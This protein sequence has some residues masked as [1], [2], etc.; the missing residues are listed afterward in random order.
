MFIDPELDHDELFEEDL[1][2]NLTQRIVLEANKAKKLEKEQ[3]CEEQEKEEEGDKQAKETQEAVLSI[4]TTEEIAAEEPTLSTSK[5]VTF[6]PTDIL[7]ENIAS[8]YLPDNE[9]SDAKTIS[10]TST[11]DYDR[12]KAEDLV[13]KISSCHSAL[14]NHYIRLCNLIPHM[15]KTQLGLYLGKIPFAPLVRAESGMVQ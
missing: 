10:S 2:G 6:M 15:S 8:R 12:D 11:T 13:Q 7:T 9:E 1:E 14:S 3:E 4:T 5:M